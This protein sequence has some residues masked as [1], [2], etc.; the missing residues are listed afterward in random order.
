MRQ[1]R[2]TESC[3]DWLGHRPAGRYGKFRLHPGPGGYT[4]AHRAAYIIFK[5][6]IP[7]GLQVRHLCHNPGCVR[8]DHLDVGTPVE[9]V[10]DSVRAGRRR[11]L[12]GEDNPA[13]KLTADGVQEIRQMRGRVTRTAIAER[14]GVD[15][16]TITSVL[17]GDTWGWL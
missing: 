6:E 15:R 1:V 11:Y 14:I 17:D 16:K 2:Q 4:G 9:N 10:G 8:P 12:R 3:W 5:G 7:D 13:A